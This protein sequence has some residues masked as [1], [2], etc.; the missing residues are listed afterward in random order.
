[1]K[2]INLPHRL[3]PLEHT[4]EDTKYGIFV[5]SVDFV[6]YDRHI[7]SVRDLTTGILYERVEIQ[8]DDST[9][10]VEEGKKCLCSILSSTSGYARIAVIQWLKSGAKLGIDA[11]A[12][13][14]KDQEQGKNLRKRFIYRKAYPGQNTNT[15]PG[16]FSSL[17]DEG[18]DRQSQDLTRDKVDQ[19]RRTRTQTTGTNIQMDESGISISGQ[20]DR[21]NSDIDKVRLPDG[22]TSQVLFLKSGSRFEVGT[23][24]NIP[25]V[26]RLQRVQEFGLD[27]PIPQ[28]AINTEEY[29]KV[30]GLT[31]DPFSKTEVSN[32][33]DDQSYIN[34]QASDTPLDNNDLPVGSLKNDGVS[35]RRKGYIFESNVGT[36]VGYNAFDKSTYGQV[37]KPTLFP[38]TKAGRFSTDV[39]SGY[40]PVTRSKDE[41][42]TRLASSTFS[43]RFPYEYNTTRFDVTKEGLLQFEVGSTIPK[44]NIPIDNSSY[45]HPHG[46]GRSVEGHF[47]GSVKLVVGKNR[48]EEE[49]LDLATLGQVVLRLGSDDASAPDSR[50]DISTQIRS[51]NDSILTRDMQFWKPNLKVGD[52]GNLENKS[53]VEKVSLRAAFDGGT[54]LR[55]GARAP[56]ALRKHLYNG[57]S[58]PQGIQEF[59]VGDSSRKDART[60]GR[61]TY[62]SGDNLYAF[63]DLTQTGKSVFNKSPY[64][65]S[66]PPITNMDR[67]GLSLDVH[68]VR[69]I[70]LRVGSNPDSGQSLA[71]DLGGGMVAYLGKDKQSR[72]I[73]ATLEGGAE[74]SISANNEGNALQLEING[75]VNI[76]C[77]GNW[78]QVISGDYYIES[79]NHTEITNIENVTK[80]MN[81]RQSAMVQHVS[82][83]IDIVHNQGAYKS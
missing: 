42:E 66:G 23:E 17:E 82:E 58:D 59:S 44:E 12:Y 31:E 50:R 21:P 28:E 16:G 19:F 37:L 34:D 51:K 46:A 43:M 54:I 39:E 41:V 36:L 6:D 27:Y 80:A 2:Y 22:S 8:P 4:D 1:M 77:K 71:I 35:Y 60:S 68:A 18:W 11:K 79:N 48:D 62:G 25:I 57:Y 63:H 7:L 81:I 30:L 5:G 65:W 47:V 70:L 49:S 55:L 45:E 38:M 3:S 20:V 24:N 64:F 75:N 32:G 72:S 26:E 78:T 73:T 13:R 76:Y 56:E 40:I 29:Q 9:T 61:P 83:G 67:H 53:A 69:D 33:V 10:V 15:T 52:A 74:I 14:P